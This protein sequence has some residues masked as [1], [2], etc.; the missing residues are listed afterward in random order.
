[1]AASAHGLAPNGYRTDVLVAPWHVSAQA[2]SEPV[3]IGRLLASP[4]ARVLPR[5]ARNS[6]CRC[7]QPA[8]RHSE[9]SRCRLRRWQ[10][11]SRVVLASIYN[12]A[13]S[14]CSLLVVLVVVATLSL[15]SPAD[16][17]T[18]I[19]SDLQ[20]GPTSAFSCQPCTFF[21]ASLTGTGLTAP[22]DGVIV[23][24]RVRSDRGVGHD[25]VLPDQARLRVIRSV[26]GANIRARARA[27]SDAG[28]PDQRFQHPD[29]REGR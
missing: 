6:A 10:M 8:Q 26:S 27:R 1:M 11:S 28:K 16:A 22:A 14:E 12:G 29:N 5:D 21:Q 18:T 4:H 17:A 19:G 7:V 20:D 15:A 13:F 9:G 3:S 25:G 24:W 2:G 23:R